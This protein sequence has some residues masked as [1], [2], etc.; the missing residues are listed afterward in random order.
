MML[1]F[2]LVRTEEKSLREVSLERYTLLGVLMSLMGSL[3]MC[4][5]GVGSLG[6]CRN[7]V[8]SLEA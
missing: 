3:E 7:L 1:K 2:S 6:V 5:N 4:G 8:D